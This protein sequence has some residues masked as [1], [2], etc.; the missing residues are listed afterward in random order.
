MIHIYEGEKFGTGTIWHRNNLAPPYLGQAPRGNCPPPPLP[1]PSPTLPSPSIL[2]LPLPFP[3]V[4][5]LP[6]L[7]LRKRE[8]RTQFVVTINDGCKSPSSQPDIQTSH[9]AGSVQFGRH[10]GAVRA[11]I[12]VNNTAAE[13]LQRRRGCPAGLSDEERHLS[14]KSPT[15]DRRRPNRSRY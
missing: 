14:I 2:S 6:C 4:G 12:G 15:L 5:Q 1:P 9:R 13:I 11:N 7:P 10:H 3:S 8:R